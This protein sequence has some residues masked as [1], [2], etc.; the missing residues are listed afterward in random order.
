[1]SSDLYSAQSF[2]FEFTFFLADYLQ[3]LCSEVILCTCHVTYSLGA[4]LIYDPTF[5]PHLVCLLALLLSLG[6]PTRNWVYMNILLLILLVLFGILRAL[7]F[8]CRW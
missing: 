6:H 4:D 1:M 5:I 8:L 2:G 3:C 7:Y